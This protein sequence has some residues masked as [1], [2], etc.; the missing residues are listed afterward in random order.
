MPNESSNWPRTLVVGPAFSK[1]YGTGT[2]ISHLFSG[3]PPERVAVVTSVPNRLDWGRCSQVYRL[4]CSELRWP[5][6]LQWANPQMDSGPMSENKLVV[7]RT[8]SVPSRILLKTF[9]LFFGTA[10]FMVSPRISREMERWVRDF[11]PEVIYGHYGNIAAARLLIELKEM[12]AIPLVIHIMDDWGENMYLSGPLSARLRQAWKRVDCDVIACA[13]VVAGICREMAEAFEQ[14]YGRKWMSV[15]MPID[16]R[17]WKDFA[18]Q[19]WDAS[20]PFRIRYG[21]RIGWSIRE[22]IVEVARMVDGF[23]AEGRAVEFHIRTPEPE[24]LVGT[25]QGLRGVSIGN[26][27]PYET[28]PASQAGA[29][30]LL[31]CYDFDPASF[32]G[33]RYS[34]ASKLTECM[35]SGTPCL[36]FGPP[37]LPV[38]EYARRDGW[39]MV[40]DNPKDLKASMLR[41]M[42]EKLIREQMGRRALE[43]VATR[44]DAFVVAEAFRKLLTSGVESKR[45]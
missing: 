6:V 20:S 38:V 3:C 43:L 26:L 17:A 23:C 41:L 10:D 4:G 24:S 29:D 33:A 15:P 31:I 42:D 37:G 45:L 34:M 2:Y 11:S 18:R 21:G 36:V 13:D 30:A 25:L 14:R 27:E 28:L 32:R 16:T 5:A 39:G 22:S 44:H 1:E 7:R 12:L 35:A 40:V 8:P 19:H 9:K